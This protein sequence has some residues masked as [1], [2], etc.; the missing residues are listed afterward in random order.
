MTFPKNNE[1]AI[2]V[3]DLEKSFK[4][5]KVLKGASFTVQRGSIF[6]LLG[7]NGAGKTTTIKILS[8]LLKPNSGSAEIEGFDV[9][10]YPNNVR[11]TISLTGQFSTVDELLTA[12]ENLMM[13]GNLLHLSDVKSRVTDLL[14]RFDLLEDADRLVST[15]SGGMKRRLDIAMSLLGNPSVIFLDEPTTGLDPKSRISM[16]E[17]IK[18]FARI[19]VTIFLTTQYLEEAEYLADK[20]GILHDGKIV[21]EG[22]VSEI[23]QMIPTVFIILHL[24]NEAEKRKAI[25]IYKSRNAEFI[26][27]TN[28]VR[29]ESDGTTNDI[30]DILKKLEDNNIVASSIEQKKPTLESVFLKIVN[31]EVE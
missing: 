8:T 29:L 2:E 13:I 10:K 23:K 4:Q 30:L 6:A 3:R 14:T 11:N 7:S 16:W 1:I 28:N 25:N 18:E 12:R 20:I 24:N 27:G 17:M 9:V 22:S 31:E 15:F 21:I 5:I 26:E 19:G